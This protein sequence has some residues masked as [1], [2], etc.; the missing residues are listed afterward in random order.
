MDDF[1]SGM[2]YAL[3][4]IVIGVLWP[5]FSMVIISL[6]IPEYYW[7]ITFG[8][9]VVTVVLTLYELQYLLLSTIGFLVGFG[10]TVMIGLHVEPKLFLSASLQIIAVVAIKY[11]KFHYN[12]WLL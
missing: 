11:Y 9:I 10:V 12:Q 1:S 6:T 8:V 7:A 4:S 2:E 3:T 5:A